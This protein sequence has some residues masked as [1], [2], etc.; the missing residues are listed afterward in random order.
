MIERTAYK[1]ILK[2]VSNKP[3]TL[4]TGARQVGK[5]TLCYRLKDDLNAEYVTL[6]DMDERKLATRDPKAFLKIHKMP[7]II[8]EVQYA[9]ELF[10]EIESIVDKERLNNPQINGLFILT[11]SQAYS[12]MENI[13]QSLS[14]RVGIVTVS[15]LSIS[16]I[17]GKKE[18]PF[19]ID[20]I[21]A[22]TAAQNQD[23]PDIY[24][25]MIR[26]MYPELHVNENLPYDSFYSD[27]VDTYIMRDVSEM[28]AVR[29]KD[30]FRSFMEVLASLTGQELVYET[31]SKAIGIDLKTIRKWLSILIAGD[32]IHLLEPYSDT[33][34]V[35]RV[36]KR[37]KIYF[38]DTGLAC[39]LAK[40]PDERILFASYL[41]GPM[42][43]TFII[44]EIIKTHRNNGLK[45]PFFYYRDSNR[46]EIDLLMLY[47]GKLNMIECKSGDTYDTG[48]V[49]SFG[50]L[51]TSLPKSGCI[52]CNCDK[53]YPISQEIYAFPIKSMGSWE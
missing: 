6:A 19:R 50:R 40:I 12:L 8:D 14:G 22:L 48:D 53:P 32:V 36:S 5:T 11:G 39:Y 46:N 44:N 18:H 27:Y 13:T 30:K 52:V 42:T 33:S 16:E 1:T 2:T 10:Q 17:S 4:I 25:L 24:S 41:R 47:D 34:V 49:K 21:G 3:V 43:E 20:P 29:D 7:L 38:K 28:T 9:P 45:T 26:G 37:P 35:K 51:P 15:P 31:I 23:I